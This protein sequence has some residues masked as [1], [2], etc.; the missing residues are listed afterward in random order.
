MSSMRF[1][2]KLRKGQHWHS[3]LCQHIDASNLRKSGSFELI[4]H[5]DR[6]RI[7]CGDL[8]PEI[9]SYLCESCCSSLQQAVKLP[10]KQPEVDLEVFI[11]QVKLLNEPRLVSSSEDF[12]KSVS[13]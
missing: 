8:L 3:A 6:R 5:P 4:T 12:V 11:I 13:S 2:I 7:L 10:P 9:G 1:V